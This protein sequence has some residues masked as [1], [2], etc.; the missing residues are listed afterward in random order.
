MVQQNRDSD[1]AWLCKKVQEGQ[2]T[3]NDVI[4]IKGLANT[5]TSTWFHEFLKVYLNKYL[6]D[7]ENEACIGKL[8]FEVNVIK[9]KSGN[10]DIDTNACSISIPDSIHL[11]QTAELL[12]KLKLCVGARLR[13]TDNIS[14]S[15]RSINSSFGTVKHL[16]RLN[17]LCSAMFVKFDDP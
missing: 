8:D 10:K 16:Y 12:A 6:A 2:Q 1:F 17:P 14:V 13:L 7:Q 4:Q 15:D 3:N 11:S 5:D 9:A